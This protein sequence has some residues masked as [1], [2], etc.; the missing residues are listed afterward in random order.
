M[1]TK[2]FSF[3]LMMVS[4]MPAL[5]LLLL[6]L[7]PAS[8]VWAQGKKQK[9]QKREHYEF[10]SDIPVY[11][12]Q[13]KQ[14]LT[15]PLAWG[16]SKTRSFKKWKKEA[17]AK[18]LECMM[19]PPKAAADFGVEWLESERRDGYTAHRL[20]FWVNAYSR[21]TAY[22]LVPDGEGPFPAVNLLHDHGAHLYIGK[23]KMIRPFAVDS[24]VVKDAG[25]WATIWPARGMWC[26]RPMPRCG[27]S[28]DARRG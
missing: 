13:L 17:R 23:E 1:M 16:N 19:T 12:E 14:E 2:P 5:L 28:G 18:V 7:A 4:R 24:A 9:L 6:M 20:S 11:V 25:M 10:A 21:I 22:L 15:Y 26:S 8:S 3:P 27:E